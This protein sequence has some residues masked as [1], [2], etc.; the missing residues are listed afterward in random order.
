MNELIQHH[1][2]YK[3]IHGIDEIKLMTKRDHLALHRK[4]RKERLCL[5]P[6]EKLAKIACSAH[7]RTKLAKE[8]NKT[9]HLKILQH[10][11]FTTTI[12]PSTALRERLTYNTNTGNVTWWADFTGTGGHHLKVIYV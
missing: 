2:K 9:Y 12:E 6:V 10:I 7:K 3:E 1:I 11:F 4:L 8:K 5:I